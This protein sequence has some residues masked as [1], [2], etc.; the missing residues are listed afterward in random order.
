MI[1]RDGR[2]R[3]DVNVLVTI[4]VVI[5]VHSTPT[6][7]PADSHPQGCTQDQYQHSQNNSHDGYD[8]GPPGRPVSSVVVSLAGAVVR[9][10][11]EQHGDQTDRTAAEAGE[12]CAAHVEE[13]WVGFG[14]D[15]WR[16]SMVVVG[17]RSGY[18]SNLGLLTCARRGH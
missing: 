2:L 11:A 16:W 8:N 14:V 7:V 9:P 13:A 4:V 10:P 15:M 1:N 3:F 18:C 6:P 17:D 12:G 5:A